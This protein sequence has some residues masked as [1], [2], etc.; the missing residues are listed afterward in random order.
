MKSG[1]KMLNLLSCGIEGMMPAQ[2]CPDQGRCLASDAD[3]LILQKT[4]GGMLEDFR[5]RVFMAVAETGSFTKAARSIG[6]SQPAVSQHI[7]ALEKEVGTSLIMRAKGE[8]SLTEA[9][10]VFR[11][12]ASR[13]LY[14]YHATTEMFGA[15]GRMTL[16]KPVRIA[17]D[18]V[19]ASYL[20]PDTVARVCGAHP[21]LSFE[22]RQL[23]SRKDAHDDSADVPGTS[24]GAPEDADVEISVSPSPETMDFEGERKLVGVMEAMV[25]A[26]P[27]NRSVVN[28]AVSEDDDELTAKPFSTIAGVPVSNRFA[29]WSEYQR[30][31]SPDLQ[32]RTAVI[33][34]S[35]EM[36]KSIVAESV[37]LVGIVPAMSVR[38]E[39]SNGTLLQMPVQLP[40]FAFDIHF[41]ALPEFEGRAV[42]RLIRDTLKDN[43]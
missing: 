12:Y 18:N 33:S 24:F 2:A 10:M 42:C 26:S 34:D 37:S 28:A 3:T 7:S 27:M 31:F 14:W 43:L 41:N 20:L 19:A 29:V 16:G 38:R 40:E 36:V 9:G 22:I 25:I 6:I 15:N 21:E 8:A 11:D 35:V 1:K 5:L 17:A 30:F 13:I 4:G 32:A 39:I 23:E